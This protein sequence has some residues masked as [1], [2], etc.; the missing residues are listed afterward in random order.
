MNF[1]QR[2]RLKK[3]IGIH[4]ATQML[5]RAHQRQLKQSTPKEL[6]QISGDESEDLDDL[7]DS[8]D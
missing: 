4:S 3:E 5:D 6:S 1:I 7:D 8:S 2:E